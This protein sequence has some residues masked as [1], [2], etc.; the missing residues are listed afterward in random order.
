MTGRMRWAGHVA[1]MGE[2][3]NAYRNLVEKPEWKRQLGR[4]RSRWEDIKADLKEMGR[5][6]MD[7]IDL[8]QDRDQL[9][10]LWTR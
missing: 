10:L 9:R 1:H 3:R 6:G 4:P 8:A 5:C 7:W 2:K